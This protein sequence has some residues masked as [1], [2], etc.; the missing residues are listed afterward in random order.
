[1]MIKQYIANEKEIF[2]EVKNNKYTVPKNYFNAYS[3]R[4]Y[5][6]DELE[7]KLLEASFKKE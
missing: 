5:D 6:V 2:T 1:M 3:Q 7:K 4:T